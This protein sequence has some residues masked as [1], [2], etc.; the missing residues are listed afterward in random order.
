MSAG[1]WLEGVRRVESPN[2]DERPPGTEITL[3][4]VHSIS[5]PPGEYGGDS[6]EKLFTNR[7]DPDAHPYFREIEGLKVSAHF[8]VRR[9]GEVVQFVPLGKRAWHAGASSWRGRT[10]CNDFSIGVELEGSD[11]SAFEEAQYL[12]LE[13]LLATLRR[14]LPLRD[15]AAHSDVAPGRKTDP[16]P[17]F[18][19]GRVLSRLA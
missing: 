19:W 12:A 6:I 2:Q 5:L 17:G 3:L 18:A 16:G 15:I 7:L 9:D 11:D 4:I 8:L 10:T 13:Q 14:T 1:G